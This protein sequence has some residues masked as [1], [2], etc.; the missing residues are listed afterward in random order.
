MFYT[1]IICTMYKKNFNIFLRPLKK[2][3][4]TFKIKTYFTLWCVLYTHTSSTHAIIHI[5]TCSMCTI[6]QEERPKY[7]GTPTQNKI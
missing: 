3:K 2:K 7:D 1:R 6:L 4:T 5:V